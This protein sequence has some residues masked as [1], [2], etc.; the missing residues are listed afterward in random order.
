M[1]KKRCDRLKRLRDER[2][3]RIFILEDKVE[4][5]K[6]ELKE[7][8]RQVKRFKN[9]M[10]MSQES[11]SQESESQESGSQES[12]NQASGS[13]ESYTPLKGNT[14]QR[15]FDT[16]STPGSAYT[17]RS[18][19]NK[20]LSQCGQN[21][22]KISTR[23]KRKLQLHFALISSIKIA[24]QEDSDS[25]GVFQGMLRNETLSCSRLKSTFRK[26]LNLSQRFG[27]HP[28]IKKYHHMRRTRKDAFSFATKNLVLA[29]YGR[30]DNSRVLPG[31]RDCKIVD[32]DVSDGPSTASAGNPTTSTYSP[33]NASTTTFAQHNGAA[34]DP[35]SCF[36][37]SSTG[38]K[39][40]QIRV[41]NDYIYN[42]YDK[43]V[44]ENP[45]IRLSSTVFYSLRPKHI[46]TASFLKASGCLCNH[47]QNFAHL[48]K[49]FKVNSSCTF[50]LSPDRFIEQFDNDQIQEM[51]ETLSGERIKYRFWKKQYDPLI[52]K[53]RMQLTHQELPLEQYKMYLAEKVD[54][55]RE[56]T[57][58]VKTQYKE[59]T[60][61]KKNMKSD[62]VLIQ[63]DFAENFSCKESDQEVQST[64]WNKN[65]VTLHPVVLYYKDL[66]KDGIQHKSF[67][68]ISPADKHNGAMVFAMLK[69]FY[70]VDLPK[71]LNNTCVK[72]MH[73]VT[74][75]PTSQYRNRFIFWLVANH[76]R[77]FGCLAIWHYLEA[78]H[79]KGPC[80]GVG[81]S[82]KRMA[83]EAIAQGREIRNA[84]SFYL[85][86]LSLTKTRITYLYVDHFDYIIAYN[87]K[88]EIMM[89]INPVP[90]TI[91]VHSVCP[92]DDMLKVKRRDTTCS[93]EL[94]RQGVGSLE[95]G[96]QQ[97][98]L[99]TPG[100]FPNCTGCFSP[101]CVCMS[102][103]STLRNHYLSK[104]L[105]PVLPG[106]HLV[107]LLCM[108][109][110]YIANLLIY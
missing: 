26:E 58:R 52:E 81:G 12:G 109:C 22:K 20:F 10:G 15:T 89:K 80:D 63:M 1:S 4:S 38:K 47:H 98:T 60:N 92:G 33:S 17:P 35:D 36:T 69:R 97:S 61:L 42:L 104:G 71:F 11:K 14:F 102:A 70:K 32:N 95:C 99:G 19:T 3:D 39:K 94:C 62:E 8:R 59:I 75:S 21:P 73:Y 43:F 72:L 76:Q 9:M 54:E 41:L 5:L 18:R 30:D 24:G 79:G 100:Q 78:G 16:P 67:V 85:W 2:Q 65:N 53:E 77:I 86:A 55:F 50:T 108:F 13:Q 37:T 6:V 107:H 91:K 88:K 7:E 29:F 48:L 45:H 23:V 51:M 93:C 82:V 49:S 57:F 64:Y 84:P 27:R 103:V 56:H 66:E 25:T 31:K 106:K 105:L 40:R 110:N 83:S 87:H 90:N 34:E 74:D 96:W 101:I 46:I 68:Y 44:F 28:Q